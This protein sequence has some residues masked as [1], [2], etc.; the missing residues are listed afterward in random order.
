M[1][2]ARLERMA[3]YLEA[4]GLR[5]QRGMLNLEKDRIKAAQIEPFARHLDAMIADLK[6][7]GSTQRRSAI[8]A[9]FWMLEEFKISIFAPEI[10]TRHPISAKRL[11]TQIK[12]IEGIV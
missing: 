12:Q 11:K 7:G 10:K 6:T 4:I 2:D 8:E 3:R 5:A 1:N 9:F